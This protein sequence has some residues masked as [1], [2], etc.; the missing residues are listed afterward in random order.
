MSETRTV[1]APLREDKPEI[2][3]MENVEGFFSPRSVA[4]IGASPKP[5][6]LGGQIV[7]SLHVQG[8]EGAVTVVNPRGEGI[9]PYPAVRSPEELPA[10]TDLAIAAVDASQVP[11]LVEPLAKRGIHHLIVIS[12]GFAETGKEG[13]KFQRELQK[14]AKKFG[15]RVMGPNGL[16]VFS[17]PNHFNS[18]FL[19]P[20][21]I[22]LPQPGP[23]AIISQ[24]GVFLSLILNELAGMGIGVHRAVNFGNRVDV[25]ESELLE[26]FAKDPAVS[27]IALYLESFQDGARFVEIARKVTRDKPIVIWKG[28][29]ADRGSAAAKAHSSSLAGSYP[30]FQAACD[31]AGLIEV[32]GFEEFRWALQVLSC[33]PV[34][35]GERVLIVSNGGGMGVFLTD[36]CE[37]A[38]LL[39]PK[40]SEPVQAFLRKKLPRYYSLEN[41]IDLTG[42]GTN[43][44][45]VETVE[46][47]MNSGEFDCLLMILLS[48]AQGINE[49]IAPLFRGRLHKNNSLITAAYGETLFHALKKELREDRIPVFPSAEAATTALSILIRRK[50]ILKALQITGEGGKSPPSLAWVENWKNRF[51]Q[52]PDEMEIKKFLDDS[53]IPVPS[54]HLLKNLED[55]P[56]AVETLGF[57]LVLKAV[58]PAL[59]HKTEMKGVGLGIQSLYKLMHEWRMMRTT[60]P[61]SVWAEQ[62]MPPGLDLMVG[63]TRDPHFGPVLVFGSGGQ[64]VEIFRDVQ[65]ILLPATHE[66]LSTLIDRTGAGKV[67]RGVRGEPPLDRKGLLDFLVQ[68]SGLMVQNPELQSLDFNPVRLYKE[69]LVVLDAKVKYGVS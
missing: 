48:G 53:G 62:Q 33:Q 19:S 54:N 7:H 57:P 42:S 31:K 59:Q 17:A 27:V 51:P 64:H 38:G 58:S 29:H 11:G 8:Y 13:E 28:G 2:R 26:T 47:L 24:S 12:G 34:P 55:L 4:V 44:Q 30:V 52:C 21:E 5:G 22:I 65:R 15:V 56:K 37:R 41:P 60:W 35:R 68:T 23:V 63:F 9:P 69:R 49:E 14:E 46:Y 6:N 25:N 45:C 43:E 3:A 50:R 39:V 66:E 32:Q 36:L 10:G 16:G 61:E 18:F 1:K 20:D 40:P 67:I